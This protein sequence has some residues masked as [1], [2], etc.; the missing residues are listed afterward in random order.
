MAL[1][2]DPI[3]DAIAFTRGRLWVGVS[4]M[5]PLIM[6]GAAEPARAIEDCRS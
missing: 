6:R 5:I 1:S 4:G 3:L 2:N